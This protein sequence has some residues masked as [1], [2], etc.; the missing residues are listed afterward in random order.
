MRKN[1]FFKICLAFIILWLFLFLYMNRYRYSEDRGIQIKVN[2][3]NGHV[4]MLIANTEKTTG[5][6]KVAD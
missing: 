1:L 6:K 3:I 2:R 5:W 4:Y